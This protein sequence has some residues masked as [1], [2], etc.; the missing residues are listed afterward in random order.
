MYLCVN[1]TW[2]P[3]VPT[4][5][6][7]LGLTSTEISGLFPTIFFIFLSACARVAIDCHCV[8]KLQFSSNFSTYRL[9][10]VQQAANS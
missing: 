1:P 4:V 5:T 2:G 7:G 6:S 8:V 9:A 10:T 3:S